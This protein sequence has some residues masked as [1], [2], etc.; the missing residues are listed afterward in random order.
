MKINGPLTGDY[1]PTT[2]ILTI[3]GKNSMG[4]AAQVAMPVQE[5]NTF[6]GWMAAVLFEKFSN[7]D[8]SGK[9][10][11]ADAI[12]IGLHPDTNGNTDLAFTFKA[13]EMKLSFLLA[14]RTRAP[15]KLAA[16][17]AHLEQVLQLMGDSDDVAKQ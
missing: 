3:S 9:G 1:E 14:I 7:P 13:G 2:R 16:I 11:I 5:P 10:L 15:E 4:K 17:R 6:I 8:G 12:T